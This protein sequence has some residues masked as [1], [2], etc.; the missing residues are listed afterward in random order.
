MSSL[1]V[2]AQR[3]VNQHLVTQKLEK[4]S[5]VVRL[6]GAVQAQDYLGAKWALSQR[7][8]GAT[9][10]TIEKEV[11]DGAIL[12]THVLR[13][14]WH[15]VAPADIRW[16]LALTAPRVK[17]IL[18]HHD[19]TLEIDAAVLRRSRAVMTRV[20][21]GGNYLTRAELAAAFAKAGVKAD[22]AGGQR[23]ARLVMH[24]ELD[25]LICSGPRREKQFTYALLD[26]RVAPARVMQREDALR[27]LAARYFTT[28][29]PASADDFAWWS[30]LTKVDAT[31]AVNAVEASLEHEVIGGR[32]YWFPRRRTAKFSSPFVRLLSNYDEYFIGHK[33][34]SAIHANLRAA[35]VTAI[36]TALSGHVLTIDGQIVG[37]WDRILGAKSVTVRLKPLVPLVGTAQRAI[38]TEIDRF[39]DFLGVPVRL[40]T[41]KP[42]R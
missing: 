39:A 42:P 34:R 28:H 33:D 19:R 30:G 10:A 24:A 3:L 2:C 27:E 8:R 40:Q 16:M 11:S 37:G 1:N 4:G 29:G 14:T 38:T 22:A 35:G 6:V 20:L 9:D 5:D 17:A 18:A 31:K 36:P 21:A 26:E 25:A 32:S 7:T 41:G 23:L 12:R 13:P 15:F